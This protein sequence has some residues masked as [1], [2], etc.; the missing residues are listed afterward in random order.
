MTI[1]NNKSC[2]AHRLIN[3]EA[4]HSF[5][6]EHFIQVLSLVPRVLG[7]IVMITISHYSKKMLRYQVFLTTGLN[8][9]RDNRISIEGWYTIYNLKYSYNLIVKKNWISNNSH[10]TNHLRNTLYLL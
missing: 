10:I 8:E 2:L 9:I 1:L 6:N 5:V 4:L 7:F 3:F